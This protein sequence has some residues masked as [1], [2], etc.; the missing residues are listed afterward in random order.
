MQRNACGTLAES[1]NKKQK[2]SL[3][4]GRPQDTYFFFGAAFFL[5]SFFGAAFAGAA[6]AVDPT[7]P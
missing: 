6:L 3:M 1:S 4:T 7:S 5:S 2:R